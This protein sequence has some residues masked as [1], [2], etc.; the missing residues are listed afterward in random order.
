MTNPRVR[1][2]IEQLSAR[3]AADPAKA[4]A[5]NAPATARLADGLR[6]ELSGP[7][8]ERLVTDMAPAIG[9]D[10]TAPNPGWMLRAALASCMATVIG[11]RAARLGI[12]LSLLEV[13]VDSDSDLRGILGLDDS[14]SAGHGP[15]RMHVK[16]S[17]PSESEENLR[18]LAQ[19]A[20]AHSPVSCT[21][22]DSP[23]FA[24]EIDIV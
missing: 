14:I 3:I 5:K 9:G 24:L 21:M 12:Q 19:W 11:M 13:T 20:D 23:P 1:E 6:C 16:M 8:G 4:R 15:L 18:S 17:A 10:G 7:R 22:R 2:A